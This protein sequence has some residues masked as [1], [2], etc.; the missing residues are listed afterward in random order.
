MPVNSVATAGMTLNLMDKSVSPATES[1]IGGIADMPSISSSKATEENTPINETT[2]SYEFTISEPPS[3]SLT[4]YWDPNDS[5]QND[6]ITAHQN[7]TKEDFL[8]KCPDSP[9]TEYEFKGLVTEFTTPYGSAGGLL[10]A[11]F[12]FQLLENDN[13]DIVTKS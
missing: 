6:L 2:R 7:E 1:V 5:P 12:T 4:V 10:Q 9:V 3:I 8:I 13:G 11:D